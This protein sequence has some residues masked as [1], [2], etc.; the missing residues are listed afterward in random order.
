MR[1]SAVTG[2]RRLV[3]LVMAMAV[4]G[5]V[6]AGGAPQAGAAD[7][8]F[9]RGPAPTS[10]SI[11]ASVGPFA[12]AQTTVPSSVAGFGGGTI[13]YPTATDQGTFGAVAI[14]PGFTASRSTIAWMGPRIASQGFVVFTIDTNSRFD[15]PSSRGT[16]LQ[17]A[18]DYL[19]QSS[20][21]RTRVDGSRLAVAGHS[22]GGGG[23]LAAAN[24]NPNLQA[25]IPLQPW[26]SDKTWE[27][28]RVPTLIIGAENDGTASVAAHSIPFYN[29]IP[30]ASE[31]AYIELNN[32]GH[33]VSVSPN[34]PTAR[35]MISWLKRWVDN[36][37]RYEQF[38]CPTP[39]ATG[40]LSA[41]LSSCPH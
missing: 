28:V 17:A 11:E 40:T 24:S 25:A 8:P 36:D 32:A 22:M 39:P 41:S 4:A 13:Y 33:T 30:A 6:L 2:R 9:E 5:G 16:Q 31:K 38:L 21:V 37:L 27:G 12:T 15:F 18:L 34:T 29:S 23:T 7:N 3:A 20:S 14:S 19:V 26:N 35:F 1:T 10:A